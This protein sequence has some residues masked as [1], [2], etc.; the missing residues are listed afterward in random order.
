MHENAKRSVTKTLNK[1]KNLFPP[2]PK[3]IYLSLPTARC[4]QQTVKNSQGEVR[5]IHTGLC[6][7]ANFETRLM[8]PWLC[9]AVCECGN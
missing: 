6:A 2:P 1:T 7:T 3:K 4:V 5:L 8:R 9:P